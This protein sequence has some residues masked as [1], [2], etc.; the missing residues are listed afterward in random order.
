MAIGESVGTAYVRILADGSDLPGSIRD[1]LQDS[2]DEFEAQGERGGEKYSKGFEKGLKKQPSAKK[3]G[4]ALDSAILQGDLA[5][6]FFRSKK[7]K[8]FVERADREFGNVGRVAAKSLEDDFI[9]RGNLAGLQNRIKNFAAEVSRAVD[10]VTRAQNREATQATQAMVDLEE[11]TR[12]LFEATDALSDKIRRES[13]PAMQQYER[14]IEDTEVTLQGANLQ[15]DKMT[16]SMEKLHT[17]LRHQHSAL[18]KFNKFWNDFADTTGRLSGRGSRNDFVNFIGSL[19]RNMTRL[20]GV[21]PSLGIRLATFGADLVTTF[22]DAGGG[23]SGLT[24]VGSSAAA[25]LGALAVKG[26]VVTVAIAALTALVVGPLVAGLSL[27][28]GI[29]TALAAS[30]TFALLGG[31]TAVAGALIPVIAGIGILTAGILS[32]DDA[33]KKLLKESMEPL[34]RQFRRLGD[35]AAGEI[36]GNAPEQAERL[37]GVLDGLERGTRDIGRA[38]RDVGDSWLDMLEG[39]AFQEFVNQFSNVLPGMIRRLGNIFGNTSGGLGGV[40]VA[41][42][43]LVQRFL[44]WLDRVTARFNK[45]ANSAEGQRELMDFFEEAGDSAADLGDLLGSL[46]DLL[47]TVFAGSKG[48]GDNLITE[49]TDALDRFDKFL[50]ENPDALDK[51]ADD[52][53][54]LAESIG[55]VILVTG[56]LIDMLDTPLTRNI[57]TLMV[58]AMGA[59]IAA[60]GLMAGEVDRVVGLV[61]SLGRVVGRVAGRIIDWFTR[62]GTVVNQEFGGGLRTVIGLVGRIITT[63]L[64]IPGLLAAITNTEMLG[65]LVRRARDLIGQIIAR[66]MSIPGI[67]QVISLAQTLGNALSRVQQFINQIIS[68]NFNIPGLSGTGGIVDGLVGSFGAVIGAVSTAINLVEQ[69]ASAIR[70]LPPVPG[71]LPDL[72][73]WDGLVPNTATGGL[74]NGAQIRRIAEAGPEAVVPLDRPL[75][76][77]DPAVRALSAIAQ[78]LRVPDTARGGVFGSTGRTIDVGGITVV[79]PQSDPRAV[80]TE[81]VNRL[82]ATAY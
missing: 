15:V 56:R 80:A 66:G 12:R 52:A 44:F 24:K 50:E 63:P 47:S 18:P 4:K 41:A 14:S 43:P 31:I 39:P 37:T 68:M 62:A 19:T 70:N 82:V 33:Q 78:G 7:W 71:R 77:V 51:W 28:V 35:I 74:F 72:T 22:K 8:D 34:I 25:T 26:T 75:H 57:F 1:T 58:N 40:F 2:E 10:E 9:R 53:E 46:T 5:N 45:W 20:I 42:I 61:G 64:R 81:V 11:E 48:S 6:T 17:Q 3:L 67:S 55:R 49:L 27:L 29:V 76:M 59:T 38:I 36:F 65:T 73:P 60:A 79:S 32:L 69:L 23:L 13:V 16:R 21:I 54:R 30:L